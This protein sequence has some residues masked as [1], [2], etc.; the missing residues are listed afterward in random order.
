VLAKKNVRPLL[1]WQY[2]AKMHNA[3]KSCKSL[4]LGITR[5]RCRWAQWN[6]KL[7]SLCRQ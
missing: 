1:V 5:N 7:Y 2:F 4:A 3:Y 6:N